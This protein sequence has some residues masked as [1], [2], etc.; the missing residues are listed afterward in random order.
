MIGE[1]YSATLEKK[2]KD[3]RSLLSGLAEVEGIEGMDQP[4]HYRNKVHRV[5]GRVYDGHREKSVS[6]IYE[7]GTHKIV[8]VRSC[9][10]ED[11]ESQQICLDIAEMAK[12]FKWKIYDEDTRVG[13]LRHVLVR[14][15]FATGKRMVTLVL[16][17]RTLPGKA[18][19]VKALRAKHPSVETVVL[20]YN[21]QKT[22]VILGGREN[23][24]YGK[25]Y[26]T[27][28]LCGYRFRISSA[29]FYQVNPVQTEK[30]YRFAAELAGL[31]GKE[32]VLDAYCGIGTIG[33]CVSSKAANVT[34]VE[35]NPKAVRDARENARQNGLD[36]ARFEAGDAGEY[37]T[38]LV[39]EGKKELL[40]DVVFMDPPRS[41]STEQFLSALVKASP[42]KIVYISCSPESLK[43]DLVWLKKHGYVVRR[44][45]AFDMF[46]FTDECE[47]CALLA[48]ASRGEA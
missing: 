24:A 4:Y 37:L 14:T 34:G 35:L 3:L 45:K 41:G 25:G 7:P 20:N 31:T 10:I 12:S 11:K 18:N 44:A 32:K 28:E 47:A 19:F 15:A 8:P 21:D 40:P 43:R 22:S 36:K 13:L 2:L 16:A 46:P 26:I 27:D 30:L 23:A 33:I 29:S 17:G 38:R 39:E 48:K 9:F 6:G 1:P 42:E 5:F